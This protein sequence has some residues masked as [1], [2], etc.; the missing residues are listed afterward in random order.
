DIA[1]AL[2][3]R[4]EDDEQKAEAVEARQEVDDAKEVADEHRGEAGGRAVAADDAEPVRPL[5]DGL[6]VPQP[7]EKDE[8]SPD[9][10]RH[11]EHGETEEDVRERT[12]EGQRLQ[13]DDRRER[14]DRCKK[15]IDDRRESAIT[16]SLE[17]VP[18]YEVVRGLLLAEIHRDSLTA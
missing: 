15:E 10:E 11:E 4:R 9:D 12:S 13:R 7:L 5:A 16:A 14:D 6:S 8:V 2:I 3:L 18:Q 1:E 17:V